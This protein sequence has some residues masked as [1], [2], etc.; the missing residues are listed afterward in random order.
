MFKRTTLP[1]YDFDCNR[2]L[3]KPDVCSNNRQLH[4]SASGLF[5]TKKNN[6]KNERKENFHMLTFTQWFILI[7]L[8]FLIC[9]GLMLSKMRR[10]YFIEL[11]SNTGP[12]F[13]ACPSLW[14]I[15]YLATCIPCFIPRVKRVTRH[16]ERTGF[17][18]FFAS[19][20]Y[21]KLTFLMLG[22]MGKSQWIMFEALVAAWNQERRFKAT[23]PAI[24]W[25]KHCVECSVS[26]NFQWW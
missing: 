12:C 1:F 16:V 20:D 5:L 17:H 19:K 25:N 6:K 11:L 13:H 2:V 26:I 4:N 10:R 18:Q 21:S 9:L 24:Y 3:S 15:L 22:W 14:C 23:W 8:C 7:A